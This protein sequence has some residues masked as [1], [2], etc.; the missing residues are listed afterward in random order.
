VSQGPMINR[1]PTTSRPQQRYDHR[2]RDL[3]RRTGELTIATDLGVPR[4]TA[5][6][7]LGA[8][9]TVVESGAG[10][11][12]GA[13]TPAGDPASAGRTSQAADP[14][15]RG[16]GARMYPVASGPPVHACVAESVSGLAPVEQ[17]DDGGVDVPHLVSSGRAQPHLR[18]RRLH[19]EAGASPAVRPYEAVPGRR[20][21]RHGAEPL[22]EDGERAGRDVTVLG[23]GDHVPDRLDLGGR[24]STR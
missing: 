8:A 16:S 4:S 18:F 6:G 13:G 14:T 20:R 5:R 12:H 7:W 2:L 24:Q 11:P 21:R 9:P 1:M 15:R 19:A 10:R 17:A 3:V 23:R 22:R